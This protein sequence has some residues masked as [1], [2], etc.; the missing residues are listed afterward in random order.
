[1][2]YDGLVMSALAGELDA[3]LRGGR[4]DKIVQPSHED[5]LIHIRNDHLNY[6]LLL[7]ANK[8][9]PRAYLTTRFRAPAVAVPPLFCLLLRKHLEGGRIGSISQHGRERILFIDVESRDELGAKVTRRLVAELMGKHSNIVLLD[10]PDGQIIDAIAHVGHAI[11]RHRELL[12]GRAYV[13]P[14]AQNKVDPFK[15]THKAF[16]A[17]R[18]ADKDAPLASFAVREYA[19]VSPF[20]GREL[21]A[22][23]HELGDHPDAEWIAFAELVQ[24]AKDAPEPVTVTDATGHVSA[25]YMFNPLHLPGQRALYPS[26]NDCA[27]AFYADRAVADIARS[28]V[29]AWLRT[30]RSQREKALAKAE[31]MQ[32]VLAAGDDAAA[33]KVAGDLL[34]AYSAQVP[35]G[36][37]EVT[38]PNFYDDERPLKI[39]LDPA[40]SALENA[41]RYYKRFSKYNR[42]LQM[43]QTQLEA[44]LQD[45]QYLDSV[46]HE[47]ETCRLEELPTVEAEL[48]EA[49]VI[50]PLRQAGGRPGRPRKPVVAPERLPLSCFIA[51]DGT[52]ILVG[53]NNKEND[54][55]TFRFARKTDIWL[56]AKGV[57]G[58]HVLLQGPEHAPETVEEAALLAAHFSR[59]RDGT[60]AEV[61][62]VP[63]RNIWRPAGA[64]PGFALFSGQRTLA[65]GLAADRVE[66]LLA[67]R[68]Q[69]AST[70]ERGR[71]D[72]ART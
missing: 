19:G 65:V 53:R 17:R 34:C 16:A 43:T 55:L 62:V 2:A 1:L 60:K 71:V 12:P 5:V 36:A 32:A 38:L 51:T 54:W 44:A 66:R 9:Y 20:F 27:D 24:Q 45:A 33:W 59:L 11:N 41:Q 46:I 48:R 25:F 22:R 30:A 10:Q 49:G 29:G 37:N 7:S 28:R 26:L 18:G 63:V 68:T 15:E 13:Y 58:S 69:V 47:L 57:P 39:A 3:A 42:G 56:H 61:D 72:P 23:A 67:T 21:A 64:K 52:P 50:R 8:S 6:R 35:H 40:L 31:K 4:I 14:P 70:P